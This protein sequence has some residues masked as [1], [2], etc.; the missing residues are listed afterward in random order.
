MP[1]GLGQRQIASIL[2]FVFGGSVQTTPAGI[3]FVGLSVLDSGPD[4]QS[5]A[6]ATGVGYARVATT[7]A[8]WVDATVA[9]PSVMAN[10][11][12]IQFAT[13]GSIWSGGDLFTHFTVWSTLAGTTEADYIGRGVLDVA[14]SVQA[15]TDP[16]FPV[17]SLKLTGSQAA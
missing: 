14:Q 13:A 7:A 4:G 2:N 11:T 5:G 17:G 15:G 9:T 12:V 8:N 1:Q 6:E 3:V 10:A 16:N